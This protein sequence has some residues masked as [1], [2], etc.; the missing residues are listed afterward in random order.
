MT[1][2]QYESRG[3]GYA[4]VSTSANQMNAFQALEPLGSSILLLLHGLVLGEHQAPSRHVGTSH[5]RN[6]TDEDLALEEGGEGLKRKAMMSFHQSPMSMVRGD[7][8]I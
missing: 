1:F 2:P 5:S 3:L 4:N 6:A 7:D 8:Q